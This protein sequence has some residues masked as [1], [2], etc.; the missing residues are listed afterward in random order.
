[1]NRLKPKEF[2]KENMP[3]PYVSPFYLV[4]TDLK[5]ILYFFLLKFREFWRLINVKVLSKDNFL[6][7]KKSTPF[8]LGIIIICVFV[9]IIISTSSL[10]SSQVQSQ[11]DIENNNREFADFSRK[12][13]KN[14][15][16]TDDDPGKPVESVFEPREA[17]SSLNVLPEFISVLKGNLFTDSELKIFL[18]LETNAIDNGV[19]MTVSDSIYSFDSNERA[20]LVVKLQRVFEELGF[21]QVLLMDQKQQLVSRKARVGNNVILFTNSFN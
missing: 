5:A 17:D 2:S 1:M 21:E 11:I 16:K 7:D 13:Y 8:W 3:T 14:S 20:S 15:E 4:R 10:F 19:V 6:S 9:F 12:V 18:S